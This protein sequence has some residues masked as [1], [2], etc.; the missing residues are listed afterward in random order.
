MLPNSQL[1][2]QSYRYLPN[3]CELKNTRERCLGYQTCVDN[4]DRNTIYDNIK[5]NPL[6]QKTFKIIEK[7]KMEKFYKQ[8]GENLEGAE[9]NNITL[10]VCLDEQIPDGFID[11]ISLFRAKTF[12]NSYTLNGGATI[13]YLINNAT[14]VYIT[15]NGDNPILCEV[16]YNMYS[17]GGEQKK[18][19]E[20]TINNVG[21]VVKEVKCS[22]GTLIVLDNIAAIGYINGTV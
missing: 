19:V 14:S 6:F 10:F 2:V 15:R 7:S 9:Y 21:R 12:L 4:T 11:N 5:N 20:I 3:V 13:E 22:N 18:D 17:I 8:I 16:R 1:Y